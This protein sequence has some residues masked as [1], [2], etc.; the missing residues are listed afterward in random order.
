MA[1]VVHSQSPFSSSAVHCAPERNARECTA[2]HDA[3]GA[4]GVKKTKQAG[5]HRPDKKKE[6]VPMKKRALVMTSFFLLSLI[7]APPAV[8]AQQPLA[9]NIPFAFTV[10]NA[11]LPAADY[12]APTLRD[13]SPIPL[14]PS[15]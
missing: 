13:D 8:R 15:P 4:P 2:S 3:S 6:E 10:G 11:T 5:S 7:A 1:L 14:T 9:V 12:P